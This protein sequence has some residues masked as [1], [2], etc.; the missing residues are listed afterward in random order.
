[1][2]DLRTALRECAPFVQD[3]E[4]SPALFAATLL[5]AVAGHDAQDNDRFS[6]DESR[7]VDRNT[8]QSRLLEHALVLPDGSDRGAEDRIVDAIRARLQMGSQGRELLVFIEG[9]GTNWFATRVAQRLPGV[10]GNHAVWVITRQA[11]RGG[12]HV[13]GISHLDL[14]F[15]H[16]P[17]WFI[18]IAKKFD[19]WTV[20][21]V[22]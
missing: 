17:V 11:S 18:A 20:R 15:E 3:G 10:T 7:I 2:T 22:N 4:G 16:C 6:L 1:M 19:R 21:Q 8:G 9:L 13:Y 12:E 5:C 14:T